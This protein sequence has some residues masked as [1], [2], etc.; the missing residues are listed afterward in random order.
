MWQRTDE[1]TTETRRSYFVAMGPWPLCWGQLSDRYE[2]RRSKCSFYPVHTVLSYP[3][4]GPT[5]SQCTA[6]KWT[7]MTTEISPHLCFYD[8]VLS[9][10]FA[11]HWSYIVY[12]HKLKLKW[13]TDASWTVLWNVPFVY[14]HLIMHRQ[15]QNNLLFTSEWKVRL[16]LLQGII[17]GIF[18]LVQLF[19]P[20]F[21]FF[22]YKKSSN[23]FCKELDINFT[24]LVNSHSS[25]GSGCNS[26]K[27][28]TTVYI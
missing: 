17:S 5:E 3:V 28:V 8:I 11:T 26:R 19:P 7:N 9:R 18:G 1:W 24:S 12:R 15:I 21:F 14:M 2:V 22:F 27:G 20:T 13:K 23:F 25:S 4:D 16:Y 6:R 10:S